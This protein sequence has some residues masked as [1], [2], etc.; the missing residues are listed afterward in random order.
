M[1]SIKPTGMVSIG[2]GE[3]CALLH[4]AIQGGTSIVG[5][6]HSQMMWPRQVFG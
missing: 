2:E 5:N 3:A 1:T 6:N 4:E